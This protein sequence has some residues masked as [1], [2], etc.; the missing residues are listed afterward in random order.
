MSVFPVVIDSFATQVGT[1]KLSSPDHTDVHNAEGVAITAL[2]TAIGTTSGTSVIKYLPIGKFAAPTDSGTLTNT[3][4][5]G[6]F[7][8][9]G[10]YSGTTGGTVTLDLT[11]SL[12]AIQLPNTGSLNIAVSSGTTGKVFIVDFIQGTTGNG[13]PVLF[14]TIKAPSGTLTFGTTAN[15]IDTIG[16]VQVNAGTYQAYTVG[17]A[18][19]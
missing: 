2:E 8:T 5:D 11:K 6:A 10:T 17:T 13:T 7:H 16:F 18:L 4:I 3:K 19:S 14:S 12:H 15:K 1:N 9:I